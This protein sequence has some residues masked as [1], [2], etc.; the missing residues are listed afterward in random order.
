MNW[1][2][3]IAE[4]MAHRG[5]SWGN[6]V[7][8]ALP[9]QPYPAYTGSDEFVVNTLEADFDDGYGGTRGCAFTVWTHHYVYFPA[10]YDGKE[11]AASVSRDPDGIPTSHVGGG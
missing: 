2:T 4:E 9:D 11:W 7:S 3:L 10:T 5:D 8:V 6:V 1:R